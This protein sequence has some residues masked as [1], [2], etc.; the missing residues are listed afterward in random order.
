MDER[1]RR[2]DGIW[3]RLVF[4]APL[5]VVCGFVSPPAADGAST[6]CRKEVRQ[7]VLTLR[8]ACWQPAPGGYATRG[9]VTINGLELR[10]PGLVRV[11]TT[12]GGV[13]STRPRRWL[14]GG[15]GI[16][17]GRFSWQAGAETWAPAKGRL[18]RLQLAG[19]VQAVFLQRGR[20][21]IDAWVGLPVLPRRFGAVT[22]NVRLQT[23]TSRPFRLAGSRI[24]VREVRVGRL[25]LR[26]LSLVYSRTRGRRDLWHGSLRLELPTEAITSVGGSGAW[27]DGRLQRVA[28]AAEG[29]VPLVSGFTLTSLGVRFQLK[30]SFRLTGRATVEFGPGFGG[31]SAL[32]MQALLD[33]RPLSLWRMQGSIRVSGRAKQALDKIRAHARIDGAAG[34]RLDQ[35]FEAELAGKL[36]VGFSRAK[37]VGQ[38]QGFVSRR[39]FNLKGSVKLEMAS[40]RKGAE[41]LVSSRGLAAC[42]DLGW[43]G[44][45]IGMGYRW[46]ASSPDIMFHSCKVDE[47]RVLT[48]AKREPTDLGRASSG[49][50]ALAGVELPDGLPLE[51]FAAISDRGNPNIVVTGPGGVR[52]DSSQIGDLALRTVV[53]RRDVFVWHAVAEHTVY[54]VV[55]SPEAGPWTVTASNGS[56]PLRRIL[57]AHGLPDPRTAATVAVGAQGHVLSY[58]VESLGPQRVSIFEAR[59]RDGAGAIPIVENVAASGT[60]SFDPSP[61]GPR[62]RYLVAVVSIDGAPNELRPLG[63]FVV[64]RP[65]PPPAPTLTG[66]RLPDAV[67]VSWGGPRPLQMRSPEAARLPAAVAASRGHPRLLQMR[68]RAAARPRLAEWLVRNQVSDGRAEVRTLPLGTTELRIPAGPRHRVHVTVTA[69][70]R[71]GREGKAGTLTVTPIPEQPSLDVDVEGEGT[72]SSTPGGINCPGDCDGNYRGATIVTLT[73]TPAPGFIFTGWTG[74]CTGTGVCTVPMTAVRNVKATFGRPPAEPQPQPPQPTAQ[75]QS[76]P[77]PQPPQPSPPS[78]SPPPAGQPAPGLTATLSV[79]IKGAGTVTSAPAGIVCRGDCA[80]AYTVGTKVVLTATPASGAEFEDWDGACSHADG[81]TCEVT[82]KRDLSVTAEFEDDDE[83]DPHAPSPPTHSPRGFST[84]DVLRVIASP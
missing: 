5:L 54:L 70:D 61:L 68:S 25:A 16:G 6:A 27:L 20:A 12:D 84:G 30:P 76:A 46:R 65:P 29:E 1:D 67:V 78:G 69:I 62:R 44:P 35:G 38:T 53:L 48:G 58:Q 4:A 42:V 17:F 37:L 13:E 51:V 80:E 52:Y 7:G 36:D 43:L 39:V 64:E 47:Y 74:A 55:R 82:V 10:G 11:D 23:S 71:F 66:A 83:C 33:F 49:A 28:G 50:A 41:A 63:S 40:F 45:T 57:A 32:A 8:A 59:T 72:V 3:G 9:P 15:T 18:G 22:G 60:I 56:A 2:D 14:V 73:P 26:N 21:E 77:Q 34:I 31:G 75:P 24:T 81:R 79:S 19:E